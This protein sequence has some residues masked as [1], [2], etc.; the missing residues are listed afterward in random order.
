MELFEIYFGIGGSPKNAFFAVSLMK[1]PTASL[2]FCFFFGGWKTKKAALNKQAFWVNDV[3]PNYIHIP[4]RFTNFEPGSFQKQT[5]HFFNPHHFC[6]FFFEKH[7]L[8][9]KKGGG[10]HD[11]VFKQKNV[12]L[13]YSHIF[14]KSR[15]A[16][17]ELS[18]KNRCGFLCFFGAL[19]T[20]NAHWK[21]WIFLSKFLGKI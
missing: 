2:K 9:W 8:A 15:S 19:S 14:T 5:V 18:K 1:F 20:I 4:L 11:F 12:P 21:R 16:S 7:T 6:A 3:N 13:G 17:P 10:V